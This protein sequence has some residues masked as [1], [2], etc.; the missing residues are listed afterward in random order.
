MAQNALARAR[1]QKVLYRTKC[2]DL[3]TSNQI[4]DQVCAERLPR[5]THAYTAIIAP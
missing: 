3:T 4:I 1:F 5:L 2:Y